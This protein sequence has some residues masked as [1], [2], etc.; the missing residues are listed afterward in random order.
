MT[1]RY[2]ISQVVSNGPAYNATVEYKDCPEHGLFE[3]Y[4]DAR[5][6]ALELGDEYSVQEIRIG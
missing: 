5:K 1:I 2:G 3:T 4:D 6:R